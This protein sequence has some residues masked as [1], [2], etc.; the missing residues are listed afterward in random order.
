MTATIDIACDCEP[1]Q[2]PDESVCKSWIEKTLHFLNED[3]DCNLSLRFLGVDEMAALNVQYRGKP[4]ATNVLSFPSSAPREL[5]QTI[6]FY[7]LG[8]IAICPPV[9]ESE[10]LE[11]GK[12]LDAHWAHIIVHGLLHLYGYDHEKS[13]QASAM[14][15]LEIEILK[16]LGIPNPYLVG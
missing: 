2:C 12:P 7:P 9:L 6:G 16:T 11:Q 4:G 14:E 13:E 1:S 5:A 15:A 3:A 8:D 10:A